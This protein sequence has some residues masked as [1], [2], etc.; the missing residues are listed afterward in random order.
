M[1]SLLLH[2][3]LISG[4]RWATSGPNSPASRSSCSF[5]GLDPPR[6]SGLWSDFSARR[7]RKERKADEERLAQN[8]RKL[9]CRI[10]VICW[11][12]KVK[13]RKAEKGNFSL[14]GMWVSVPISL[15]P[16]HP[17]LR[18]RETPFYGHG[19]SRLEEQNRENRSELSLTCLNFAIA[20]DVMKSPFWNFVTK[21]ITW[22]WLW[23]RSS[24]PSTR[25]F[26]TWASCRW[27]GDDCSRSRRRIAKKEKKKVVDEKKWLR[28]VATSAL[29]S[30]PVRFGGEKALESL[31][32]MLPL[33]AVNK[34][35]AAGNQVAIT[36]RKINCRR[37]SF[38]L[39]R[40]RVMNE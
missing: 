40:C 18:P 31:T 24:S 35:C 12:A 7:W 10:E 34:V 36:L 1:W 8:M 37:K 38:S 2:C 4:V 15:S 30:P 39:S 21:H 3:K 29:A 14:Y 27:V 20:S 6:A 16:L 33:G 11:T 17:V 5:P 9:W 19:E 32:L 13:L 23:P 22:Y 26:N 25:A 28:M